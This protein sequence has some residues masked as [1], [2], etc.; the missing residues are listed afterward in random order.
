MPRGDNNGIMLYTALL[1]VKSINGEGESTPLQDY[2]DLTN[3]RRLHYVGSMLV[4]HLEHR[5]SIELTSVICLTLSCF[6]VG[7]PSATLAQH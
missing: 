2:S 5:L 4:Q 6:N 7:P 1:V 3:T